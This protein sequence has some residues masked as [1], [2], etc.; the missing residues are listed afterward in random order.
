MT[1]AVAPP[2]RRRRRFVL[3]GLSVTAV[4]AAAFA[5]WL[6]YRHVGRARELRAAIAEVEAADPHWR[7][8]E[9][10]AGRAV[11]PDAENSAALVRRAAARRRP[12]DPD[13]VRR[14]Q[15]LLLNE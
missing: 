6:G 11:V 5:V 13:E 3:T 9:I 14:R 10:E 2:V 15:D 12:T 7:I 1:P 4:M 8:E